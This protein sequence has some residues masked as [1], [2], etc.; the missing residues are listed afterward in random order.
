MKILGRNVS[1]TCLSILMIIVCLGTSLLFLGIN[2]DAKTVIRTGTVEVS[3]SLNLRSGPG[4][5]YSVVGYLKNGD[6][7]QIIEEKKATTGKIWYKMIVNGKTGWASSSYVKVT[8]T[9]VEEDKDFDAYLA[10][11]GFPESYRAQLQALHAKYPNWKFEAQITNLTWDEV[12][13]G[14][15]ALGKNLVHD[16]A[17]SS[18]KSTQTG[19]YDWEKNEWKEFDSGG[20]VAASTEIIR[21]YMDPRNFLDSTNIFQFIKQSYNAS[22]LN[23]TQLAQKKADLTNMVKGTYLAGGCDNSTYVDVIMSVAA[24]TKVCPFTLASMMIQEQGINGDGRSISGKV[25]GYEGY[26]NYLNIGAY[27]TSSFASAVE[28]G[29]WYAKGG[30][31]G[32]TSYGR[33]WNT[34][35]KAIKGGALYYGE[36]FVNVGQDTLYLKKFNV[37]GSNLYG[38]QY[39]TNVGGAA[40][41]GIHM[42]KAYDE[43]AR[44]AALI[45]KIPVY[46]NM[47]AAVSKKPSGDDNPNYM[48]KSLSVS[49]YNL[50]PT[51][52][53]YETSYSLIVPN[54]VTS[55]T[56]SAQAASSTTTVSGT[57]ARSLNVGTNA[58]AITTKAQNGST[59]TYTISVVRQAASNTGGG[60]GGT[61]NGGNN[62]GT[63]VVTPSVSSTTYKVNSNNTITGITSFPIKASDFTKKFAVANGSVKITKSNGTAETGNVGTGDQVRVYDSTGAHKFTYNVVIY[64]DTNGDGRINAQD[65]LLIQKNNIRVSTLNGVFSSAADV[66]KN[67]KV[68]AQD[69]LLVQKH[70]IKIYTIKQ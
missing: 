14:E 37:Q 39:M 56:V 54:S 55:I 34:R 3:S 50:T 64:G 29:L 45:F 40:S 19:A 11:Q 10:A 1:R 42:S 62:G 70:N 21:Y 57:G 15:S 17:D 61:N 31:S 46:K 68:N 65:L 2:A 22:A 6:T 24:S 66:N 52:S 7:G 63:T 58:I 60:N 48:L 38:H 4:T 32:S 13:K 44:E 30:D 35:T 69:L 33:P 26:Y 53:M 23:A 20:W 47:P 18:W 43:N 67:G 36:N 49:G 28:R 5:E 59:R 51:F 9:I 25:P 27:K 16:S 41:E 8:E 12:I